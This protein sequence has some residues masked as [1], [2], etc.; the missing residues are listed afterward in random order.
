MINILA[1]LRVYNFI[2][3]AFIF[4]FFLLRNSVNYNRPINIVSKKN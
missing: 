1:H 2:I 4:F 3:F